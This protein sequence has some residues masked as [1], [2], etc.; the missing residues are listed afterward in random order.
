[1]YHTRVLRFYACAMTATTPRLT[2][3]KE[4]FMNLGVTK[5]CKD[6]L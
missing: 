3:G 6:C 2:G 4:V 1:M 5:V